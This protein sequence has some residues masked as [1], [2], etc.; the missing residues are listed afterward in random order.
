MKKFGIEEIKKII[1][2]RPPFLF[3]DEILELNP[4]KTIVAK[5]NVRNDEFWI[6]GHFPNFAVCP[7][8]LTIEMLAQAGAVCILS[9]HENKGKIALFGGIRNARFKSQIFPGDEVILKLK[10]VENVGNIGF[11]K[12]QAFVKNKLAVKTDLT[13][14]LKDV[15]KDK[16]H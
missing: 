10:I 14:A 9:L 16:E 7:G 8:V 15:E 13:F 5:K 11:G 1:P 2:H 12:A 6:P 3:L 4:G